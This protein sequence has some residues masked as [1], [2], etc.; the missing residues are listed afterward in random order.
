M[1]GARRAVL[2]GVFAVIP[3]SPMRASSSPPCD[4]AAAR[5]RPLL[6]VLAVAFALLFAQAARLGHLALVS[7]VRCEH[8]ALVHVHREGRGGEPRARAVRGDEGPTATSGAIEAEHEHCD[9]LSLA[10]AVVDARVGGD[11][12]SLLEWSLAPAG[13]SARTAAPAVDVLALAPKGSPPA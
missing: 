5:R 12:P 8:G 1:G 11:V 2:R 3:R 7:H 10:P 13:E 6:G 4:R 9:A